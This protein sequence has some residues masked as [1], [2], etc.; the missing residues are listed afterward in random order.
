MNA[1]RV[2]DI[3]ADLKPHLRLEA[4]ATYIRTY[5]T[6]KDQMHY[7]LCRKLGLLIGSGVVESASKQ[8]VGSLFKRA[9]AASR[10]RKPTLCSP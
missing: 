9:S 5:E 2:D 7:D 3:I 4:V 1:G 6:N 10:R 8:I